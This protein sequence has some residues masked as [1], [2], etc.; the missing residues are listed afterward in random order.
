M[1]DPPEHVVDALFEEGKKAWDDLPDEGHDE[2]EAHYE[3]KMEIWRADVDAWKAE[4]IREGRAIWIDGQDED[5]EDDDKEGGDVEMGEASAIHEPEDENDEDA[6]A[7]RREIELQPAVD[8][9]DEATL[10]GFTALNK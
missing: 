7:A 8:M 5:G 2:H 6:G 4:E 3:R 9:Q 1:E 10:G